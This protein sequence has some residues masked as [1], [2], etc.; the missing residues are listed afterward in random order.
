MQHEHEPPDRKQPPEALD[1]C[2]PGATMRR[3]GIGAAGELIGVQC[4]VGHRCR[5]ATAADAAWRRRMRDVPVPER[6]AD[7]CWSGLPR[8]VRRRRSAIAGRPR[9]VR[10]DSGRGARPGGHG[11]AGWPLRGHGT[12]RGGG[13]CGRPC[14]CEATGR[15]PTTPPSRAGQGHGV[16]RRRGRHRI[17][18]GGGRPPRRVSPQPRG[19][20]DAADSLAVHPRAAWPSGVAYDL[21]APWRPPGDAVRDVPGVRGLPRQPPRGAWPTTAG[22]QRPPGTRVACS[23]CWWSTVGPASTGVILRVPSGPFA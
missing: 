1:S 17:A 23:T 10:G 13:V 12:W 5:S 4:G 6:L 18:T 21:S 2:R 22:A 16:L 14:G 9:E 11:A 20:A 8:R 7:A 15:K 19:T 3:T